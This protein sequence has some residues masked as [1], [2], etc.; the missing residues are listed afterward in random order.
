LIEFTD[1]N[2]KHEKKVGDVIYDINLDNIR[3]HIELQRNLKGFIESIK[4]IRK[5]D[6]KY[7]S[8]VGAIKYLVTVPVID[9]YKTLLP[10]EIQYSGI[11]KLLAE[12]NRLKDENARILAQITVQMRGVR[13]ESMANDNNVAEG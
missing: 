9:F 6:H 5:S 7:E 4:E 2:A 12:L 3:Y 11:A 13:V 1:V 8:I 10:R